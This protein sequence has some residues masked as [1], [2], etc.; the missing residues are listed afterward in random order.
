MQLFRLARSIGA[1]LRSGIGVIAQAVELRRSELPSL[2]ALK[3]A[4]TQLAVCI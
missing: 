1:P 3:L 2:G 4:R